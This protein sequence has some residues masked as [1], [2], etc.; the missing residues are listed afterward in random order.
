MM[1]DVLE[2]LERGWSLIPIDRNSKLPKIKWAQYQKKQASIDEIKSWGDCNLGIVC[3]SISGV[4]VIDV[5]PK[6]GGDVKETL[7]KYHTNLVA[8]TPSGGAHLYFK[9]PG[10]SVSNKVGVTPGVDIRGDGGY[11]VAP[12]SVTPK[13]EYRWVSLG[14]L[15][16]FPKSLLEPSNSEESESKNPEGWIA[17][18]LEYGAPSGKRN[19]SLAALTGF[20]A[21]RDMPKD[22]SL[23]FLKAWNLRNREPIPIKELERS[24]ESVYST[25]SRKAPTRIDTQNDLPSVS[26][27]NFKLMALEDY[28]NVF[29]DFPVDWIVP[30]WLPDKT[31]GLVVS[32]PGSYKTWLLIDL[33]VSCCT[34]K[35]FLGMYPV[36]K[37]GPVFLVQQEDFAGQTAKR[38]SL[39]RKAKMK[40]SLAKVSESGE[41]ITFAVPERMPL[42]IHPDRK[43]RFEDKKAMQE[44]EKAID[45]IR[46]R[47]IILDPLYSVGGTE[48]YMAKIVEQMFVFKDFRDKYGCS[49]VIA[50]HTNKGQEE[51]RMRAW[52]SQFI[53]AFLETGWQL[54]PKGDR[55]IKVKRHFKMS[56]NPDE[57]SLSF[58]IDD[59]ESWTYEVHEGLIDG[60]ATSKDHTENTKKAKPSFS[61]E[62]EEEEKEKQKDPNAV[63]FGIPLS[64]EEAIELSKNKRKKEKP[65]E[66]HGSVYTET[67][68]IWL[69]I[70]ASFNISKYR[71]SYRDYWW[72]VAQNPNGI[73]VQNFA[74]LLGMENSEA[75]RRLNA[76]AIKDLLIRTVKTVNDKPVYFFKR[77]MS[78]EEADPLLGSK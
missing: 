65:Q 5:D 23:G 70:K 53:N 63:E 39:I 73:S 46:P 4:V 62:E 27:D 66:E 10:V 42:Y 75:M 37:T 14:E 28:M 34:G 57:V 68:N 64:K 26:G 36:T 38:I 58:N 78:H 50:H 33:A 49:F 41:E 54:F 48:D 16:D 71:Y 8:I 9:H 6:N 7:S 29:G 72:I 40:E 1:Q 17:N 55:S 77:A 13:G 47:I 12:P 35:P 32:P 59:K 18:L 20:M 56:G 74:E 11:V 21:S 45:K 3:G 67:D 30:D 2:Y 60:K 31:I 44:L 24:I 25:I 43:L 22:I 51:G 61:D 19:D 76:L 52:G 69:D 15:S